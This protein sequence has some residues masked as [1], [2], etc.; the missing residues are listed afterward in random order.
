MCGRYYFSLEDTAAFAKLKRKITQ[1]SIF[2]YAHQEVFP[3]Q[4]SLVLVKDTRDEDYTLKTMKWGIKGYQGSLLINARNE[5]IETKKTFSPLLD[6]R[7]LIPCNGFY[8]WKNKKK[9]FI[10][11]KKEPLFYLA[12]IYNEALE[13]VIVTG[14]AEKEMKHV[15]HRTPLIIHE[16]DINRY[17]NGDCEFAVDNDDLG[18]RLEE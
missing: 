4:K 7:C 13:F 14:E 9:V 1:M 18:F 10:F 2:S 17:L 15:H 6:H 11:E 16:Q 12:G 3:S 8:E 5:G